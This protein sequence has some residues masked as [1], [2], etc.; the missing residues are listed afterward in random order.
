[1]Q[2]VE[3]MTPPIIE[4]LRK[5][6]R[7]AGGNELLVIG[8]IDTAGCVVEVRIGARG[9]TDMVPALRN[10]I[11]HGDVLIHNHPS[12]GLTPSGADLNVASYLAN[13]GIGFYIIDNAVESIY[14][15]TEPVDPVRIS[16]IDAASLVE[17]LL[18]G[19]S[20]SRQ[21]PYYEVRDSQIEMLEAVTRAFNDDGICVAE[22]GTGVGKSIAYLLPAIRWAVSN[23]ERVVVSTATINL[24]QQLTEKDIPL[25]RKLFGNQV[26]GDFK[27]AL[28]K[29]RGNYLCRRRLTDA[30]EENTLFREEDD[31]LEAFRAWADA[32]SSGSRSEL[33]FIPDNATWSRV[34]S[35]ADA[36]MGI[37]CRY[38][39][40]CFVL[41]ARREAAAAS[42]L[43]TNHHL[44]F[45][46]LAMRVQG[47]G[48]EGSAVLPPYN[49]VIFD[50]AHNL[51]E[52]ARSYFSRSMI[53]YSV[54]RTLSRLLY[55]R[56]GR[57][58]GLLLRVQSKLPDPE[59]V[60]DLPEKIRL[61]QNQVDLVDSLALDLMQGENSIRLIPGGSDEYNTTVVPEITELQRRLLDISAALGDILEFIE[62]ND[63]EDPIL[64]EIRIVKRRIEET[65]SVCKSLTNYA[66]D[67]VHV[68]WLELFRG[69]TPAVRFNITPL[70]VS[71]ILNEA[72]FDRFDTI[73]NTSATLTIRDSFDF[74]MKNVGLNPGERVSAN[75]FL[76]PFDYAGRVMLG[77][78][79]G[80]PLPGDT[81]YIDY[82]VKTVADSM[83]ISGGRGLI[84][85]TSYSML[86]AVYD[87]VYPRLADAGITLLRQGEE[88]RSRLL[89]S[90]ISDAA[91]VL[92]ATDSFWEGIDVP[93]DALL[94]V[95]ICRLPF[96]V[97]TDPVVQ[98][99]IEHIE[100]RGGNSF[101]EL[102]L[103]TAV[104]RLKQGFGRL[105]RRTTDRG[106][107]LI[108]DS[109]II[110]KS[111][112]SMFVNSLPETMFVRKP[113][114]E[115][116]EEMENFLYDPRFVG[117]L[118]SL[119]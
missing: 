26:P 58:Y 24:Q 45:A 82:V 100:K 85:F 57:R 102:T 91:S 7:N 35:E 22:A 5:E 18:P 25:A 56:R 3:R 54:R 42:L 110:R 99:R 81:E 37:R 53:R 108:L 90:F 44:L 51:E 118:T 111:Y 67:D 21:I 59:T 30:L 89:S 4:T 36:C 83:E 117:T 84:L 72:L 41:K 76:S 16:P 79:E 2:I 64:F 65:C 6:I 38:R 1:M 87:G 12:G 17:M 113:S 48:Y 31:Q 88:D 60:S 77:V 73:I 105:M 8:K 119:K 39:E 115:M 63:E 66:D 92:F 27:V 47:A 96:L 10:D 116:I 86:R 78:P 46:D 68:Y 28:V 109:R 114:K 55:E 69:K 11:E 95:I 9:N 33:S 97:P 74:W 29:G 70:E 103:P 93:G 101:Y 19:G 20:F 34:C 71:D 15:V 104:I 43:V 32:S 61:V 23:K 14:I 107:V 75:I 13:Q 80:V 40:E 94:V 49:R 112:G 50:E 106:V 52:S 98:A 62:D